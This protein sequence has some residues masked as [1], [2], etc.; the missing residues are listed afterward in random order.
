MSSKQ[1]ERETLNSVRLSGAHE[2]V[3]AATTTVRS[4]GVL[5]DCI[6]SAHE[7]YLVRL[8]PSLELVALGQ[9]D[10]Q[11]EIGQ[12]TEY[13]ARPRN[14]NRQDCCR[15]PHRVGPPPVGVRDPAT[16]PHQ[17]T[18]ASCALHPTPH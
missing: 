7:A 6:S 5:V 3:Q 1:P 16:D 18:V 9:Q 4:S 2:Q 14:G 13:Q 17:P 11:G 15:Q 8:A 10:A 12:E